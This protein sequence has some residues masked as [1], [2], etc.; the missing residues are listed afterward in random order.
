MAEEEKRT[1]KWYAE[2]LGISDSSAHTYGK[3]KCQRLF[4]ETVNKVSIESSLVKTIDSYKE[5]A[6]NAATTLSIKEIDLDTKFM[7]TK[8]L[9]ESIRFIGNFLEDP[10]VSPYQKAQIAVKIASVISGG[11]NG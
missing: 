5:T 3:K 9:N 1:L 7:A 8:L 10:L 6:K 11:K 2:K 4:E